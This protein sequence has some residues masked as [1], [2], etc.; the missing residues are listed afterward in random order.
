MGGHIE[1][2]GHVMPSHGKKGS[3]RPEAAISIT[4]KIT[5]KMADK[6]NQRT[7]G[8][9]INESLYWLEGLVD[10]TV[11]TR[12]EVLA[13]LAQAIASLQAAYTRMMFI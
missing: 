12:E 3:M 7:A 8:D 10:G 5:T 9:C 2:R 1:L 6:N 4:H 13:I 11:Q